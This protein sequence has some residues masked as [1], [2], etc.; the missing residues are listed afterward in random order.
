MVYIHLIFDNTKIL[1]LHCTQWVLSPLE[2]ILTRNF[3][4][5][6]IYLSQ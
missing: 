3:Y 6:P 4:F 5:C 1:L 2:V